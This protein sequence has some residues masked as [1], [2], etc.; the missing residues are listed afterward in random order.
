[1]FECEGVALI[2]FWFMIMLICEEDEFLGVLRG[3]LNSLIKLE[4]WTMIRWRHPDNAITVQE[5]IMARQAFYQ[6][7]QPIC[8]IRL[9]WQW[10][11]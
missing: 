1:M 10:Q 5:F 7:R 8:L 11:H 6:A 9:V 2:L 4:P 3:L